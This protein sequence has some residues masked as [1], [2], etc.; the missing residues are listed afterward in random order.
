[1]GSGNKVRTEIE[2]M[3]VIAL[4]RKKREF[5]KKFGEASE[6]ELMRYLAHCAKELGFGPM[7]KD[8]LGAHFVEERLNSTWRKSLAKLGITP[9]PTA[10]RPLGMDLMSRELRRQQEVYQR[11]LAGMRQ[12]E[13]DF[14]EQ[15]QNDSDEEIFAYVRAWAERLK[16]TPDCVEVLGGSYIKKRFRNDWR[17]VL[18]L[19]GL[20]GFED[21]PPKLHKRPIYQDEAKKQFA[22]DIEEC[23]QEI[24]EIMNI[25]PVE[26][27]AV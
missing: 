2:R 4:A 9:T 21:C 22:I 6:D 18:H 20:P 24:A 16:R 23:M 3:A 27:T 19:S 5:I 25:A 12:N 15:H 10:K 8:V 13:I 26:E 1:M 14:A 17:R 11:I 7:R